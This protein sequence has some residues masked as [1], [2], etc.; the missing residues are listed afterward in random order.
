MDI[1]TAEMVH[2][3]FRQT[4]IDLEGREP[5]PFS[6]VDVSEK[7]KEQYGHM[8]T[9]LIEQW[10][11]KRPPI[12]VLCGSTR[13]SAAFR[14]ANF[15][16]TLAGKIVLTIG[17]DTKSDS[18]LLLAGEITQADKERLDEL[19]LRKID[20]ADEVFVLNVNG[21]LGDSTRREIAYAMEHSKPIRWLEPPV[22][23]DH[24]SVGVIISN[25]SNQILMFDRNTFP[26]GRAC[27]A[28][29]V[30][31]HGSFEDAARAETWEEVGLVVTHLELAHAERVSF[32]C[33]RVPTREVGHHCQIYYAEVEGYTLNPSERET[34]NAR[35]YTIDEINAARE[36]LEPAWLHW[37]QK[38][39]IVHS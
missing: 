12:V 7:S 1:I 35:W 25:E 4:I 17:V 20:L 2:G 8:A 28:G 32:P 19:H 13:F 22:Y 30:D 14:I 27:V 21:Y 37:F 9:F 26:P 11:K 10:R 34:R 15:Q 3:A 16:E 18:D 36:A 33:R 24:R 23:C 6:Y 31:D 39:G 5:M 38:L 29:H